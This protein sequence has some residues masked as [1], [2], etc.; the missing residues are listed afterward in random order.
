MLQ[1]NWMLLKLL[2]EE[3]AEWQEV[4]NR[5]LYELDCRRATVRMENLGTQSTISKIVDH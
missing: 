1:H 3:Q 2:F 4:G 5:I